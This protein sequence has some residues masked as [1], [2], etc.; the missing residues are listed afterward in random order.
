MLVKPQVAY[1]IPVDNTE[2]DFVPRLKEKHNA[3]SEPI[4]SL[5]I[6]DED[7][8]NDSAWSSDQQESAHPYQLELETFK[9]YHFLTI[10]FYD[11]HCQSSHKGK[12][13]RC[14][15]KGRRYEVLT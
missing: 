14:S 10:A 13:M 12:N 5:H 11:V 3:V 2:A 1:G 9:V 8:D 7:C 6:R 15:P 4:R